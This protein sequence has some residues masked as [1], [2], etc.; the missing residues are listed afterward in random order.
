[1]HSH[2]KMHIGPARNLA[3]SKSAGDYI[4]CLDIDDKLASQDAMNKL[5][6]ALDGKDIYA[7]SYHSRIHGKDVLLKPTTLEQIAQCPVACWTKVYKRELYVQ[8][9]SYMPEDVL[10]HYL[11]IDKC[12]SVGFTDFVLVD[13]DNT[14]EN[15]G[16][17]SRTFDWCKEHPTNLLQL[18]ASD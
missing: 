6:G 17:I 2:K 4:L 9:P 3:Y 1:M 5:L 13:Y 12:K 10:A 11:L 8:F 15:K 7:C 14:P 18:A 16:A